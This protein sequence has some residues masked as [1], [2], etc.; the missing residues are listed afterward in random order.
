MYRGFTIYGPV[1]SA[2]IVPRPLQSNKTKKIAVLHFV[3]I[4][5]RI[6]GWRARKEGGCGGWR[7][8]EGIR[9]GKI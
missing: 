3:Q 6:E 8:E 4:I 7:R 2:K 5:G 9:R 1:L